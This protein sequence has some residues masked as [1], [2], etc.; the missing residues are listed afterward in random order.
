MKLEDANHLK[1][2][3]G[4]IINQ[5]LISP[6]SSGQSSNLGCQFAFGIHPTG[7]R[8]YKLAVHVPDKSYLSLPAIEQIIAQACG[9]IDVQVT[10]AVQP[11]NQHEDHFCLKK[12]V[13]P[14]SIG[15]SISHHH[16]LAGT[17][18]LGCFVRKKQNPSDLFLLSSN[19]ILACKNNAKTN[20][21]IIQPSQED[22]GLLDQNNIAALKAFIPLKN[23]EYNLVDA[24]IAKVENTKVSDPSQLNIP[25]SLLDISRLKGIHPSKDLEEIEEPIIV[26]KLGRTTCLTWGRIRDFNMTQVIHYGYNLKYCFDEMIAIEGL[27]EQAFSAPG[28]SG[29]L[30]FDEQGYG[31]ALLLGGTQSGGKNNKG[32]TY[33]NPIHHVFNA[34]DVEIAI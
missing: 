20:D 12:R 15:V 14:L 16:E 18:T 3:A 27:K 11:Y 32:I 26:L 6:Y 9:E 30:I 5:Q 19:H 1:E 7:N 17:G 23:N 8:N 25:G 21:S 13:R 2:V 34:L 4:E 28:D 10:G 22:G 24:A 29:S 31:V 33:A